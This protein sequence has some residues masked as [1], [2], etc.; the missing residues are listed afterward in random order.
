VGSEAVFLAKRG[1]DRGGRSHRE[2]IGVIA[3]VVAG[4]YQ[5]MVLER[6]QQIV[7]VAGPDPWEICH[8]YQGTSC[9]SIGHYR[10][11]PV[12]YNGEPS[13]A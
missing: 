11:G 4:Q 5:L 1:S 8:Q 9:T 2:R 12:Y 3:M 13:F 7:N 10:Q 6:V